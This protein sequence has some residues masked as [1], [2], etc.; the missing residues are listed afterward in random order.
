MSRYTD[1]E[2]WNEKRG[3]VCRRHSLL[4]A[5]R[6]TYTPWI[7]LWMFTVYSRDTTS[8]ALLLEAP[9]LFA[10]NGMAAVS[11]VSG[12]EREREMTDEEL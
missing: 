3:C 7:R 8:A 5:C 12:R 6:D 9:F 10:L 1:P 11:V 4:Q 2:P